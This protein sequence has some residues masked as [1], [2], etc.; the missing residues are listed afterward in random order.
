VKPLF[1]LV[2][3]LVM[4]LIAGC[5]NEQSN[6]STTGPAESTSEQELAGET[7]ILFFDYLRSGRYDDAAGLYGGSYEVL[8]G[9][10]PSVEPADFTTLWRNGCSIN[11][12][13]CLN[14]RSVQ[15]A[16][17]TAT[18]EFVF[19]VEF[20][21]REGELFVLGPCCGANETEQP[22]VSVWPIRVA[23][24]TDNQYRVMDMPSY[25]P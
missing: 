12:L 19:L 25:S 6:V 9:W 8:Q 4:A 18:G 17:Q 11:G 20:S 24:G 23:K 15:V 13:N 10:N 16:E 7:A 21:T 3:C 1:L 14:T 5:Q 2:I 22:P